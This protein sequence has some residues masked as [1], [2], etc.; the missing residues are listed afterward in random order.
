M[1]FGRPHGEAA[2]V[3]PDSVS[4]QVFKNPVARRGGGVAAVSLA[5]AAPRV[6]A[7]VGAHAGFRTDPGR[8]LQ[9]TGLAALV[10]VY[11][12]RSVAEHMIAG[13]GRMHQGVAGSTPAG[14]RYSAS[15]AHLLTWVQ[16]TACFGFVEAYC[17]YVR[18]LG[19]EAYDGFLAEST[20]TARLYGALHAPA[21][22][23]EL[24]ALFAAMR[25]RLEPSP[26]VF[27][28]LDIMRGVP[29]LPAPLR[30][31]QGM[32]VRAAVE[33][34]PGWVRSALGL[35]Q[36]YGLRPWEAP[37]VRQVGRLADRVVL[38]S[39]PAAQSCLRVGLPADHLYRG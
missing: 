19:A 32:L 14:E 13:I 10:T 6:R 8:R 3:P 26:V 23:A 15:D 38:R 37:L 12:A 7:G 20:P 31:L 1:D 18:P 25:P 21:C 30:P 17:R 29:I 5:R 36:A 11:A 2:L 33:V 39:G 35:T 16:A 27:E 9:R 24:E 4:W 34:V 28:F 22:R